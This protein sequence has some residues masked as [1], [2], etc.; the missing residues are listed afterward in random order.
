MEKKLNF[1]PGVWTVLLLLSGLVTSCQYKLP[2]MAA[3]KKYQPD[4]LHS[5]GRIEYDGIILDAA[6]LESICAYITEKQDAVK[7]I[8]LQLGT[9]FRQD[10]DIVCT[11]RNPDNAQSEIDRRLLDWDMLCEAAA[12]SQ[13]VPEGLAVLRPDYAMHI[14]G[15]EE[16]TDYYETAVA[17]NIS[18]GKAAWADGVLL[19]GNGADNKKAYGQ[20]LTDGEQ[21]FI[22]DPLFPIYTVGEVTAEIRHA[23]IGQIEQQ[24]GTSGC[25]HNYSEVKVEEKKCSNTLYKTDVTWY[26]DENNPEGGTWHG[27]YYTCANHGGVYSSPGT[28]THKSTVTTTVWHHDIIC[29][30]TDVVY[31]VLHIRGTDTDYYD[32]EILLEAELEPREGYEQFAWQEGNELLWADAEG[33]LSGTGSTFSVNAPGIYKCCINAANADIDIRSADAEVIVAGLVVPK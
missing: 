20:G 5:T 27:G 12:Q 33:N 18:E 29:G 7:D 14:E 21:T 17:D 9:K 31:A 11:D 30:L 15:V 13:T 10:G 32:R 24:E 26:P 2:S 22:P 23:H 3:E 25:Y 1:H 19:L 4:L 28:C 8:L 6:D 16:R